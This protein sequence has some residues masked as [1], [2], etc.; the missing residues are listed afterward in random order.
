[1]SIGVDVCVVVDVSGRLK[2]RRAGGQVR[3]GGRAG[4]WVPPG[5][6]RPWTRPAVPQPPYTCF[7]VIRSAVSH[8]WDLTQ[9][10]IWTRQAVN[11]GALVAT[12]RDISTGR[13][14]GREETLKGGRRWRR[15]GRDPGRLTIVVPSLP[16]SRPLI[17]YSRS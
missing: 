12:C 7:P 15:G 5:L 14:Q 8:H 17:F 1:M 2:V 9:C 11:P 16:A 13:M 4:G 6:Q 10:A 3:A